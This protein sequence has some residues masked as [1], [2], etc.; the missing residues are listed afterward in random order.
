MTASSAAV[1]TCSGNQFD[2]VFHHEIPSKDCFLI[3]KALDYKERVAQ[4]YISND[5]FHF[6][7]TI[8]L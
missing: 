5:K 1:G 6:V 8:D 3:L 7:E 4:F 2:A